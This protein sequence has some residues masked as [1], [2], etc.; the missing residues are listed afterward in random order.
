MGGPTQS[1][2]RMPTIGPGARPVPV[3]DTDYNERVSLNTTFGEKVIAVR[4]SD[5]ASQFQYGFP[6][7]GNHD[8]H[9]F[10]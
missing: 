8:L 5:I 1:G 9:H 4:K 7:C 10:S 2:Q 6:A 3:A